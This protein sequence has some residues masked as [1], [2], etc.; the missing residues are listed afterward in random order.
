MNTQF[1]LFFVKGSPGTDGPP[2]S[3]GERGAQVSL[4]KHKKSLITYL[5]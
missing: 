1:G 5:H 2:G 3:R 4:M